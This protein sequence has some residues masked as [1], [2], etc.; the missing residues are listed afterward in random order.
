VRPAYA[1]PVTREA[2][3]ADKPVP[4]EPDAAAKAIH[5]PPDPL[6]PAGEGLPES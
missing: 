4:V 6:P 2:G 3:P 1:P 5:P